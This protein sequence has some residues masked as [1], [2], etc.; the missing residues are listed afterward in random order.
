MP[1]RHL[2]LENGLDGQHQDRKVTCDVEAGVCIPKNSE[3][4]AVARDM[5]IKHTCHWGTLEDCG[6]NAG[7]CVAD[8]IGHD[9]VGSGTKAGGVGVGW[10]KGPEI[11]K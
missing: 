8:H 10:R 7:D 11:Q 9:E 3:V 4:Y 1:K 5:F 2:Q 6:D